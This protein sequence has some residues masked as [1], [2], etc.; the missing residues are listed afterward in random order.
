MNERTEPGE[1]A[2]RPMALLEEYSRRY[3]HAWEGAEEVRAMR[4]IGGTEAFP[5]WCYVPSCDVALGIATDGGRIERDKRVD[6]DA[7]ALDALMRWRWGKGVFELD[8]RLFAAVWASATYREPG[9]PPSW[10]A[11]VMDRLRDDGLPEWCGYVPV[12]EGVKLPEPHAGLRGFFTWAGY[13]T[14]FRA[15]DLHFALDHGGTG[16]AA[17]SIQ[18]VAPELAECL[19]ADF[20]LQLEAPATRTRL[21]ERVERFGPRILAEDLERNAGF[22][23]P[24]V[25]VALCLAERGRFPVTA[26]DGSDRGFLG[27]EP[28]EAAVV[29]ADGVRRGRSATVGCSRGLRLEG[30]RRR[31]GGGVGARRGDGPRAKPSGWRRPRR[32]LPGRSRR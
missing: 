13:D 32:R 23:A 28:D 15:P 26:A 11:P 5:N 25:G 20:A 16:V 12:P 18:L 2:V 30:P 31:A 29:P 22:L 17:H 14:T 19:R 1:A 8:E 27:L 10:E 21:L 9:L 7:S 6:D 3:P 4:T 24:L